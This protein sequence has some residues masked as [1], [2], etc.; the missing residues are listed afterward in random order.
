MCGGTLCHTRCGI[1]GFAAHDNPSR[2][3]FAGRQCCLHM[4]SDS[5]FGLAHAD[6]KECFGGTLK[7]RKAA[8]TMPTEAEMKANADHIIMVGLALTL[9]S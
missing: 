9:G 8:W 7:E 5:C 3:K 6:Q 4:H 1:C 2:G